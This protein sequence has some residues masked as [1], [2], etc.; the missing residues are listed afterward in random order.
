MSQYQ[1]FCPTCRGRYERY[2]GK[3]KRK[4]TKWKR[5]AEGKIEEGLTHLGEEKKMGDHMMREE[6]KGKTMMMMGR[7]EEV[8]SSEG[9]QKFK[10]NA[11]LKVQRG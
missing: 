5:R 10:W 8:H 9:K 2:G 7:T 6:G 3:S 1:G 4:R 11:L